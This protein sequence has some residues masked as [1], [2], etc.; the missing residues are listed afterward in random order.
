MPKIQ[1]HPNLAKLK[2]VLETGH[3]LVDHFL[4]CGIP[5]SACLQE[6]LYQ[7]KNQNFQEIFKENIKPS[8]ISRFPEFDNSIDSVD[9][10]IIN[11][12]FPEGFLPVFSENENLKPKFYTIL[13]D[14]NLFSI[15]YPQKYLSC[16]LFYEKINNYRELRSKIEEEEEKG[17]Y[18]IEEVEEFEVGENKDNIGQENKIIDNNDINKDKINKKMISEQ[19]NP[20]SDLTSIFKQT[21]SEMDLNPGKNNNAIKNKTLRTLAKHHTSIQLS[22]NRLKRSTQIIDENLYLYIP[23]VICLVSI[24]PYIKTFEKILRSICSPSSLNTGLVFSFVISS[25]EGKIV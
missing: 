19:A 7:I 2:E 21:S 20:N 10:E 4:V 16:L 17:F 3:N 22:V 18:D 25:S 12:C 15:E 24:H 9:D 6:F 5:P 23:K 13:L 8:I 11:Y 14:N 1:L